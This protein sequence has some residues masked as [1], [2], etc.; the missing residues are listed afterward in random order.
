MRK[1]KIILQSNIFYIL[2]G[3]I[4]LL[5][6]LFVTKITKYNSIYSNG[7]NTIIGKVIKYS[8]N[9]N[10]LSMLIKAK[11]KIQVT[12]FFK[13]KD[14]IINNIKIGYKIKINGEI[15]SP[16]K[17]TIPN[18]FNYQN[19]L[20][21]NKIYKVLK[22]KDI[23]IISKENNF[24][25]KI[26][27]YIYQKASIN[28]YL[29]L[30]IVGDKSLL[31]DNIYDSFKNVGVAHLL[32]IS[33]MHVVVLA[34]ISKKLLWFINKNHQNIII[35]FFLIFYAYLVN[36]SASI[37]RVVIC[38][39]L[40][41]L[42]KKYNFN[43][44]NLNIILLSAFIMLIYN[45]FFIYNIGFL[46][47]Y[48]TA[49]GIVLSSKFIK[50]GYIKSI[51]MITFFA[52]LFTL[53]ITINMNF[54][55]NLFVFI[56]NLLL[57]PFITF[58]IYPFSLITFLFPF[59]IKIFTFL[60]L[61]IEKIILFIDKVDIL[62]IIIPK[63]SIIFLILYYIILLLFI[64]Y[65]TKKLF[66]LLISLILVNKYYLWLNNSY[67]V[68]LFDV[69]QGDSS[70][71]ISPHYKDTI[72]IDTGG[73]TSFNINKKYYVSNNIILYL[74]SIGISSISSMIITHGDFDHMGEAI[75]LV[76]NF[77]VEKVIFNCGEYNKLEQDL[78]K[79]LDKKKIP[80]Y[81]CIK[82]LNIDNN[83][84]YFLQT[85]EYDNENDNSNVIYTEINDYKF[86]FMG[87]AGVEKE[88][89]ILNKY[90]IS[91][92]DVLKVGHHGS[93]TS[94]SEIFINEMNPKYSIISVGKNNRYGHPNKEVLNVLEDSKIYRT[95]QDGSIMFKIKNKKLKIETCTL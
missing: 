94:S 92:I 45:P 79:V 19:Y 64:Y 12:F 33:G 13:E 66:F 20:Y 28:K 81:S 25:Q 86:M 57:I 77:K 65:G 95:D 91:N 5:E 69:G 31:E 39:I 38:F 42:N 24:L 8:I 88:K 41:D 63:L 67:Q 30:F 48:T 14:E 60:T 58:I 80:Y 37:L 47:S 68:N 61:G 36:F 40:N 7:K 17:N 50:K 90:N 89:D 10:K 1:L 35:S 54:E 62:T 84:L 85:K 51:I 87:D 49:F 23:K 82:E 59:L 4:I 93:K 55:I 9:D 74:K 76:E 6:I 34:N 46:Y 83:K 27:N 73:I 22:A 16:S 32:A 43:L 53:P 26:K 78:I 21:N 71:I 29:F 75:N 15:Q 18:T 3:F 2:I 44:D 56:S 72:M 70:V 52:L 11:E